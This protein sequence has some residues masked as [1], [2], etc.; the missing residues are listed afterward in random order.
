MTKNVA[1]ILV[2]GTLGC[3]SVVSDCLQSHG[4]QHARLPCLCPFPSLSL[5]FCSNSCPLCQWFHPTI[6]SLLPPCP[7]TLSLYQHQSL[8]Q[9]VGSS[10]QV[11]SHQG[12]R[13]TG[14]PGGSDSK[15][16]TCS[17]GDLDSIPVSRRSPG[18]GNGN[19]TQYSCLDNS[20]DRGAWWA[21]VHGVRES[22]T[23]D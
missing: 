5:R 2:R 19:T 18:E 6:S 3:C 15:A 10:H 11:A 20:M 9:W 23:S 8:L 1:F 14:F 16:L 17:A 22:G 4:L 12:L 21:T 13:I 7:P